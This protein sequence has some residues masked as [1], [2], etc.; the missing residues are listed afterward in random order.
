MSFM[1]IFQRLDTSKKD[2]VRTEID[3]FCFP[4]ETFFL[5]GPPNVYCVPGAQ[6]PRRREKTPQQS[7]SGDSRRPQMT[8][9]S[10]KVDHAGSKVTTERNDGHHAGNVTYESHARSHAVGNA[11]YE[12][13]LKSHANGANGHDKRSPNDLRRFHGCQ[14]NP[15]R[16]HNQSNGSL[17][18]SVNFNHHDYADSW[19]PHHTSAQS[20]PK[21]PAPRESYPTIQ[22]GQ[23]FHVST[24]T[25]GPREQ[26]IVRQPVDVF[27]L[28]PIVAPANPLGNQSAAIDETPRSDSGFS[29]DERG[30]SDINRDDCNN[31]EFLEANGTNVHGWKAKQTDEKAQWSH[32]HWYRGLRRP[33]NRRAGNME[34]TI[35]QEYTLFKEERKRAWRST[36]GSNADGVIPLTQENGGTV[37]N[38][39]VTGP[40]TKRR[41]LGPQPTMEGWERVEV[42]WHQMPAE[43]DDASSSS[44]QERFFNL[45][46]SDEDLQTSDTEQDNR[47][48][49]LFPVESGSDRSELTRGN[50]A[51]T[52]QAPSIRC[53]TAKGVGGPRR[54]EV[55]TPD[56]TVVCQVNGLF[57]LPGVKDTKYNITLG[58]LSRRIGPPEHL[59]RVEMISYLRHAKSS[60]REIL[61]RHQL[62]TSTHSTPNILS[63]VCETEAKVLAAG[64]HTI[65]MDYLPMCDLAKRTVEE[66][67]KR[68]CPGNQGGGFKLRRKVV[69]VEITRSAAG[70]LPGR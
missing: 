32:V 54:R 3:F 63:R 33:N 58:E 57:S 13:S 56:S 22:V 37:V 16:F 55:R 12:Q 41:T 44:S 20:F 29:D 62:I 42:G 43:L 1:I 66:F 28:K 51:V 7:S 24:F 46:E 21:T 8:N 15:T 40:S 25:P 11:T 9:T 26:I 38:G 49:N 39:N 59:N 50:G 48:K 47:V 61:D 45:A 65:N 27:E 30:A 52:S 34:K 6:A 67:K 36:M 64:V 53:T 60:A 10:G 70:A 17:A 5:K 2:I 69:D 19:K 14:E 35:F 18:G 23:P 31:G 68:E 4:S